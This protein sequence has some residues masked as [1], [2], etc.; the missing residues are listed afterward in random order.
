MYSSSLIILIPPTT[1]YAF[2]IFYDKKTKKFKKTI[3]IMGGWVYNINV[4]KRGSTSK[5]EQL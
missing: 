5:G 3:V 1:I 4:N 2:S